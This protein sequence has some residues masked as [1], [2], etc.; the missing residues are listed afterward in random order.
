MRPIFDT[1]TNLILYNPFSR[2]QAPK[3][4][5]ELSP[6][7]YVLF[8]AALKEIHALYDDPHK[9]PPNPLHFSGIP[10]ILGTT[11]GIQTG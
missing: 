1:L 9:P 10:V 7:D 2:K 3:L 4:T 8:V 5:I 6:A 11:T